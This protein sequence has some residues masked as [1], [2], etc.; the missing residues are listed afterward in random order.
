[1]RVRRSRVTT[2]HLPRCLT[3]HRPRALRRESGRHPPFRAAAATDGGSPLLRAPNEQL[4][5][6]QEALGSLWLLESKCKLSAHKFNDYDLLNLCRHGGV[7]DV[8]L[9][10]LLGQSVHFRHACQWKLYETAIILI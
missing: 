2:T 5:A 7:H 4:H 1:M 6:K 9:V 8:P 10:A 3:V